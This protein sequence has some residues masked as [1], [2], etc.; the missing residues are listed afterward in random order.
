V[1]W[2]K[3]DDL[4]FDGNRPLAGLGHLRPGGFSTLFCDG[5]VHFISN[6][7]N[8]DTLRALLSYGGREPVTIPDR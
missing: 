5:S 7:V 4:E 1:V 3:P 2:T 6:S 8:S